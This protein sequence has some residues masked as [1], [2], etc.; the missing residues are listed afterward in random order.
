VKHVQTLLDAI[1]LGGARVQMFNLS[2]AQGPQFAEYC[3]GF[4]NTIIKLGP[5]PLCKSDPVNSEA[6]PKASA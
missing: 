4:S 5:N 6:S 1:G 3:T 2:S